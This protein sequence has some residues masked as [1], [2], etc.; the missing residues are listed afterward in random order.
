MSFSLLVGFGGYVLEQL[1]YRAATRARA[2]RRALVR[3]VLL[4]RLQASLRATAA[5]KWHPDS[6]A[7]PG[8]AE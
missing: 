1:F 7:Q 4:S 2:R 6:Y 3:A 8:E 5:P